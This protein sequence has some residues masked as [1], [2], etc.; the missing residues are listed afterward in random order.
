MRGEDAFWSAVAFP[1]VSLERS[2]L[3]KHSRFDHTSL[4]PA[5]TTPIFFPPLAGANVT[6]LSDQLST[7][8]TTSPSALASALPAARNVMSADTVY[9]HTGESGLNALTLEGDTVAPS[10]EK[11]PPVR[12]MVRG[13]AVSKPEPETVRM[14]PPDAPTTVGNTW[15]RVEA[16]ELGVEG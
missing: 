5:A 12:C 13:T 10:S 2:T 11:P 3:K 16:S 6:F 7:T 1:Y 4:G 15:L 9:V 8:A 14:L